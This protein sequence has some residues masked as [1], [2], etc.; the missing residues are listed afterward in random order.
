MSLLHAKKEVPES[1]PS[2]AL[3]WGWAWEGGQGQGSVA[4]EV[5]GSTERGVWDLLPSPSCSVT[6]GKVVS[7]LGLSFLTS[8]WAGAGKR[9]E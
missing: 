9:I 3:P 1:Q 8:K 4:S 2:A 5:E 6:L 7:L